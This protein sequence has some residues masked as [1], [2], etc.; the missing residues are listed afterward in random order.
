MDTGVLAG[1]VDSVATALAQLQQASTTIGLSL[2]LTK[3]EAIAVGATPGATLTTTSD[4]ETRILRNF[5]FLGAGIGDP[6]YLQAHATAR[7]EATR[8]LLDAI[9]RLEDPQ[10][11]LRLLRASAGFGRLMHTMR[12]CPPAGHAVA[13]DTFD[14][15]VQECFSSFTGL[16]LEP[17][18]WQQ[19]TRGLGHA[20]LGLRLTR[21]HAPAAYLASVGACVL[22]CSEL[23]GGYWLDQSAD[24][25]AALSD[26][27]ANLPPDKQFAVPAALAQSQ[28]E[29]NRAL[30][31]AAWTNQLAHASAVGKAT[32][33][34]EA[35][36][37][38]GGFLSCVPSGRTRMEP[39]VFIAELRVRLN[40]PEASADTWCPRCDAVL[41]THG[42]HSGMYWV[43][44]EHTLRHNA[45]RDLVFQWCE[46]GCLR[47]ERER[48]GLLLPQ[49]SDD[50]SA[51]RHRPADVFLP[52]FQG[53]PIAIDFAVTAP[54]RLDVLGTPGS[55]TPAAAAAAYSEH[56]RK[57]LDTEA[58]CR[59][60]NVHFL[61]LVVETTG[62]WAPEAAKA[63]S[64]IG[65]AS[66]FHGF[67][68]G[69]TT[70]LQEACV[71]VR[72]WRARAA[73]RRRAELQ[74]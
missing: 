50:L 54:Q 18:Q 17:A 31:E 42:Y 25:A 53:R 20:G 37:G 21:E 1:S 63:L 12:C 40:V 56:K 49:Q 26:F 36:P 70:L 64:R 22:Q 28:K 69:S 9:G 8:K 71:V 35:G 48:P 11:A 45:L 19:A 6:A 41:D 5:E 3:S 73:L 39:L 57:H 62:A 59:A 47:P 4:G 14:H 55:Y 46:R 58:V 66:A 44:G 51:A 15:L 2:N 43:G 60:Q 32:L 33:H 29:L 72:S 65:R 67:G 13:L 52:S 68:A 74:P 30:D 61:S 7:V 23:D 16:Y 10:V 24:V 38:A 27:N 34:S